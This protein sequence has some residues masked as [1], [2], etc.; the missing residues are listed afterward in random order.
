M[1]RLPLLSSV[2]AVSLAV[3]APAALAHVGHGDEFQAE[4]GVDRVEVNAETDPL[5]GIQVAPIETAADGS[6]AVMI[7]V[8]ALVEDGDRQLVFVLYENFYEPVP[9]TTGATV[10]EM[11]EILEGL[12]VGE[13]LVTQGSLSLYAESRKTQTAEAESEAAATTSEA[14]AEAE[15]AA[16]AP[17]VE[18][19][20]METSEA[21][22]TPAETSEASGGFPKMLLAVLGGGVGL[23][24]GAVVLTRQ[25]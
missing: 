3:S 21:A 24:V 9:V 17:E 7:P 14:P 11:V 19:T 25:K 10:G 18:A 5:L 23:A 8:A 12:S 16:E 1:K 15:A 20:E 2:L 6:G 22:E 13:Q 4:G